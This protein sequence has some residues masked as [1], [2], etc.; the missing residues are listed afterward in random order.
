MKEV[1]K[2]RVQI[3]GLQGVPAEGIEGTGSPVVDLVKTACGDS[4][5]RIVE[6]CMKGA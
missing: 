1:P 5:I 2:E 6:G 3:V 4:T